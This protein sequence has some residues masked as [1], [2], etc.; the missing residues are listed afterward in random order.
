MKAMILA[1]GF[2]TRL[3]PYTENTP[4][5]LF[6]LGGRPLLDVIIRFLQQAGC[7]AIII[8]THHLYQKIDAFIAGQNYAIPVCTRHEP[9]ILGTGGALKNVANFWDDRPFFLINSDIVF[10]LDL[11]KIY[12]FHLDHPYPA[13]LVLCNDPPLNSVTI[14]KNGFIACFHDRHQKETCGPSTKLTFTGIHVLDP[15]IL[16]FIP[17]NTFSNIVDRYQKVISSG[18]KIKAYISEKNDWKDIGTP[19]RYRQ[20]VFDH[21]APE[22]F[23]RAYPGFSGTSIQRT[24]LHGDGSD[25]TWYRLSASNRTLVMADHGIRKGKETSEVDS[26]VDIGRHLHDKGIPVP[27]IYHYDRFSGMVFLDDLGDVTLQTA[28]RRADNPR[29]I[30]ACYESVI[31]GLI[32]LSIFGARGFDT[33]WTHQTP[34]YSKELILE[35]ECLYF[36]DAFLRGYMGMEVSAENFHTEFASLS[37]KALEYSAFGFMHRDMQSRNIMVVD[38]K[39]YF[40]DFQGGR[41]G[42]IQYDLASLLIDPYVDLPRQVQSRLLEYSV[43]RLS[44]YT[45]VNKKKFCT[46]FDYCAITR[47]LQMLGAFGY[48]SRA[49]GKTYFEQYIPSAVKTLKDHLYAFKDLPFPVLTS[50][51]EKIET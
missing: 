27:K 6:T 10:D 35:K 37:D 28:V 14:T 29:K 33:S 5:P 21:M 34:Y 44:S 51:V 13:T 3:L 23:T 12:R 45:R 1:A 49:K 22:A 50:V 46:C 11:R 2:G 43:K 7:E 9:V 39:F 18:R 38:S 48:L 17:H 16:D 25:R 24:K 30:I 20:A 32:G 47:S 15:I 19:E 8:N 41:M 42:P 4:K 36:V 40:I 26:F 31:N